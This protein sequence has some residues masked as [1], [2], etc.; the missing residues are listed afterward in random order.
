MFRHRHELHVR[1]THFLEVFDQRIRE[2]AIT[3]RFRLRLLAPGTDVQFVDAQRRLQ[4]IAGFPFRDPGI[5]R[6]LK[7][8]VVPNY[9][10]VLRRRFEEESERVG[11]EPD[12][13][14]MVADLV[15][16]MRALG[17]AKRPSVRSAARSICLPARARA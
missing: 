12:L 4:R 15:L 10:R 6:P 16:V 14:V 13:P 9:R 17:D 2:F 11:L 7:F 3:E 8:F 5:I 1:E